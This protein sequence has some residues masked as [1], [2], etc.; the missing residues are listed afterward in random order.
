MVWLFSCG[1]GESGRR[2]PGAS[3]RRQEE[4]YGNGIER[5]QQAQAGEDDQ[6]Q[7]QDDGQRDMGLLE[8]A[9]RAIGFLFQ[10][11]VAVEKIDESDESEKEEQEGEEEL[12]GI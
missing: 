2:G 12:S 5:D 6:E 7:E 1:L 8:A 3:W 9:G 10:D 11:G 4:V